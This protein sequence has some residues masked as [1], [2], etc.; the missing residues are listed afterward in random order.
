[1]ARRDCRGFNFP[2]S[3]GAGESVVRRDG[4]QHEQRSPVVPAEHAGKARL[5]GFDDL[6][7]LAAGAEQQAFIRERIRD[8]DVAI[9]VQGNSIGRTHAGRGPDTPIGQTAGFIDIE[10]GQAQRQRFGD[11]QRL[12]VRRD[13]AAIRKMHI[14]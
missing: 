6:Q 3:L 8:P 10:R 2:G 12:A 13:H 1:M 5:T 14:R 11:D 4:G 7:D 9:L